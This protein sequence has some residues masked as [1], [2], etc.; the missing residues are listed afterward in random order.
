MGQRNI[1]FDGPCQDRYR[2]APDCEGLDE[3]FADKSRSPHQK[4]FHCL[5]SVFW[6][7]SSEGGTGRAKGACPE[8]RCGMR[9]RRF[10]QQPARRKIRSLWVGG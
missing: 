1:L 4:Y 3:S 5:I 8:L 2:V 10:R 9:N 7:L 6:H